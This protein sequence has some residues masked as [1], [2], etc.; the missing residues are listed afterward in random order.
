MLSEELTRK[1]SKCGTVFPKSFVALKC[2]IC[3]TPMEKMVCCKCKQILPRSYFTTRKSGV[4]KGAINRRCTP[5]SKA[6][7]KKWDDDNPDRKRA[8]NTAFLERR[9]DKADEDYREML[10]ALATIEFK[11]MSEEQ[12]LKTC[13]Y[14]EGCAI[15]G[16]EHIESRKFF[17]Q[18]EHGGKYAV[19]N[20]L[21]MCWD[22]GK[23]TAKLTNPFKWIDRYIGAT[24]TYGLTHERRARI[25]E[26]FK[27][28]IEEA[29]N[30]TT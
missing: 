19:W 13:S 7:K 9:A 2:S 28:K 29:K 22:C 8:R 3:G 21:P 6:M 4:Y 11:P 20:I 16:N 24:T 23:H 12:W 15:C 1:C 18:F 14:F 27:L 10:D 30:E 17:L 5:C 26:Y 25:L